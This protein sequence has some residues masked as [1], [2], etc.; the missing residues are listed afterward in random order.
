MQSKE[1]VDSQQIAGY[2]QQVLDQSLCVIPNLIPTAKIDQWYESFFPLLN[3]HIE[4]EGHKINRGPNRYY[5]TLPFVPPF[6][7]PEIFENDVI[8]GVVEQ[9]IGKDGVMCQLATDTPL[10]GSDYQEV[11]R[12]T[13]LLFPETGKESP[14]YQLAVNFPLIDMTLEN[15]PFEVALGTHMLSKQEGLQ[16][17]E[18]GEAR[19]EP[20]LLKKGDVMI[21]DVRHLHRGTPNH[22][23]SPRPMV[24]IGYSRRWLFRPEVS[25]QVPRAT[26]ETLS[27]RA[28]FWLRF[29]PIV[30]QLNDGEE[31]YQTFAY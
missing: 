29:N 14:P 24:V 2:A 9:I 13:Q 11:H 1:R 18:T 4:R 8:L 20:V 6:S 28:K 21:R 12:D 30:E 25:I 16:R 23:D 7:D 27:D 15:G 26:W 19:L 5:V 3:R 10:K 17:L 22:T 31:K